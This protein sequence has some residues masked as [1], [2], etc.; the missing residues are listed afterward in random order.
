MLLF[1]KIEIEWHEKL[2]GCRVFEA[3]IPSVFRH[4]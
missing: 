4:N 3:S 1:L 2:I